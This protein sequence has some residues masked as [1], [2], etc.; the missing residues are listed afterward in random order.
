LADPPFAPTYLVDP[1]IEMVVMAWS[2][3][4]ITTSLSSIFR[5]IPTSRDAGL[6]GWRI[7]G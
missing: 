3:D 7:G 5:T 4:S 6:S 1:E 2:S